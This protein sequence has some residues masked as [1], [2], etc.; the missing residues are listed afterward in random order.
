MIQESFIPAY[1]TSCFSVL[2]ALIKIFRSVLAVFCFF[3]FYASLKSLVHV[4]LHS[5]SSIN[6]YVSAYFLPSKGIQTE[7]SCLQRP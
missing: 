6:K 7:I 2:W 4:L 3:A 5:T 1:L